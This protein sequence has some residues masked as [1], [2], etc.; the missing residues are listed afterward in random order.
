MTSTF[1]WSDWIMGRNPF[2]SQVA[3]NFSPQFRHFYYSGGIGA[4]QHQLCRD[5]EMRAHLLDSGFAIDLVDFTQLLIH[6]AE[7]SLQGSL[8]A[9]P[10]ILKK[11]EVRTMGW[12][13]AKR[14]TEMGTRTNLLAVFFAGL[15]FSAAFQHAEIAPVEGK[16][17]SAQGSTTFSV[18]CEPY[19]AFVIPA[20]PLT[21]TVFNG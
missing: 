20:L 10:C 19:N 17:V 3:P 12:A 13:I 14:T 4:G 18:S 11:A 21:H 5:T 16:G 15:L 1:S 7:R 8:M 9:P 2:W 6:P